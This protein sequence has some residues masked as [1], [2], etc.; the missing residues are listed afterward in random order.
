MILLIIQIYFV[1]ELNF[2]ESAGEAQVTSNEYSYAK[3]L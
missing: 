2:K 3:H 1:L